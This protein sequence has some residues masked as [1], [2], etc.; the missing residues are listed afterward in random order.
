MN[1]RKAKEIDG[2]R[3]QIA[4]LQTTDAA[5]RR[6]TTLKFGLPA[7]DDLLPGQGLQ[8]AL[9]RCRDRA[10]CR[11]GAVSRR[12][13]GAPRGHHPL[14]AGTLRPLR[15]GPCWRRVAAG[16]RD[17]P[18]GRPACAGRDGRRLEIPWPGW[19]GCRDHG[20]YHAHRIAPVASCRRGCRYS[21]LSAAPQPVWR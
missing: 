19:G 16:A 9:R 10:R 21:W 11:C 1:S 12:V 2:L 4:R 14:G 6:L 7:I 8:S 18:S 20:A 5:S 13:T 3:A 15:A 17:L